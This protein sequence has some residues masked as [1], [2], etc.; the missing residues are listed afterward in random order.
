MIVI[1]FLTLLLLFSILHLIR[2]IKC[3]M[4][5]LKSEQKILTYRIDHIK[6]MLDSNKHTEEKGIMPER[7]IQPETLPPPLPAIQHQP[8]QTPPAVPTEIP[9]APIKI[10]QALPSEAPPITTT[11]RSSLI[12]ETV[13]DI[14]QKM[15][16]WF[17]VGD[18]H[19]RKDISIEY[20]V[21]TTWTLRV[22][23]LAIAG[24]AA[25]FLILSLRKNYIPEWG[26]AALSAIG[27]IA[28]I[29]WA[30]RLT[31][32]KYRK[33]NMIGHG[34]LGCG[35]LILYFSGYACGPLYELFGI[36]SI[37]VSFGL[38]TFVTAGACF[39]A[40]RNNSLLTAV[41]GLSGGFM[42]PLLLKTSDPNL[43]VLFSY[44][45]LL[46]GGVLAV[47]YLRHWRIL[48]YMTFVA[49]F[50][51][52]FL[53]T[54]IPREDFVTGIIF[55][56]A[57]FVI[58]T[59]LVFEQNILR[60]RPSTALE[61]GYITIAG[62]VYALMGYNLITNLF[63]REWAG[64]LTAALAVFY[65][66]QVL[67]FLKKALLDKILLTALAGLAVFFAVW[68]FP[69][70][71][72][73]EALPSALSMFA[74]LLLW[75]G[76]KLES[77]FIQHL[78]YVV[79][80]VV[81]FLFLGRIGGEY[82]GAS[83]AASELSA[84]WTQAWERLWR[85]GIPV[86]SMALASRV[87]NSKIKPR[88]EF[89][90]TSENDLPTLLPIDTAAAVFSWIALLAG[91]VFVYFETNLFSDF[92]KSIKNPLLTFLWC[93]MSAYLISRWYSER[94]RDPLVFVGLL[95]FTLIAA[96]KLLTVDLASWGFRNFV[97][98]SEYEPFDS[99]IRL[100]DF[101]FVTA[102]LVFG[103]KI[104]ALRKKSRSAAPV[105]GYGSIAMLFI[106]S[107]LELNTLLYWKLH[108]FQ[109]GGISILWAI[110]AIS[111]VVAGIWKELRPLRYA[112]LA[113]F[114]VVCLKV[115]LVDLARM[116][117]L[118]RMFALLALGMALLGGSFAYT[119]WM[120]KFKKD[121]SSVSSG[122]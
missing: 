116:E 110:F 91:F 115:M 47:G 113:L 112:G 67:I 89:V 71:L 98:M 31:A 13:Q 101:A 16:N 6:K 81:I 88:T 45:L 4:D 120:G 56:T 78:G 99:L 21:A 55:L 121:D 38:M 64:C 41:V 76:R 22:G 5:E 75:I 57:Y 92:F 65:S 48:N 70:V 119:Y 61:V 68:T 8:P 90:V 117:I 104:L 17:I 30:L 3:S 105:F 42:T 54:P 66:V 62:M 103:W 52:F 44:L 7:K 97:F 28:L 39:L 93:A 49:T 95:V 109:S 53:T 11:S 63:A 35:V 84:Y 34:L 86:L 40:V 111:F 15:W 74:L 32:Q 60:E 18:E 79:Y 50:G 27:G 106:F 77:S 29:L 87:Q 80:M 73:K 122:F 102:I 26:R 118:Y 96:I 100:M 37:P 43:I 72:T 1:G 107:T 19:R 46:N 83:P 25:S 108:G 85:F 36:R 10:P 14:L 114:F 69:I 51:L 9:A 33:Y 58:H 20:A 94:R 24:F 2:G 82:R 59:M 23:I 12:I